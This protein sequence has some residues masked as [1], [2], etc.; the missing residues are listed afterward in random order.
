MLT[1]RTK[2]LEIAVMLRP[3]ATARKNDVCTVL[4]HM[5]YSWLAT[6]YSSKYVTLSE[7]FLQI[8]SIMSKIISRF[9][10]KC[11]CFSG[12]CYFLD[13][14]NLNVIL[15]QPAGQYIAHGRALQHLG[16]YIAHGRAL[17][18]LGQNI[19]HGS[20]L[21]HWG[22]YMAHWSVLQH[23]GQNIAHGSTLQHLYPLFKF[24]HSTKQMNESQ[25]LY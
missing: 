23:L 7:F 10:S 1:V 14:L 16:Q 21:Q 4:C 19:A 9:T 25:W 15:V 2:H 5:R 6:D 11:K 17:Q 18:N 13:C 3:L 12:S 20:T 24:R 22:Q 8:L